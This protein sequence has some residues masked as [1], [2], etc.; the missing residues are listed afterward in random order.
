MLVPVGGMIALIVFEIMRALS[1][2]PYD[3]SSLPPVA[4]LV[5]IICVSALPVILLSVSDAPIARWLSFGVAALMSLFHALHVIEHMMAADY[6]MLTLIVVTML[7]PS[8]VA[9]TQLWAARRPAMAPE[10]G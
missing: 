10:A 4:M 6:V 8:A 7:L 9:A 3:P 2:S 5:G 1:E